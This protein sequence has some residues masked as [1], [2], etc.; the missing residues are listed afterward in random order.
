MPRS[1][2]SKLNPIARRRVDMDQI[3]AKLLAPQD[4]TK[5]PDSVSQAILEQYKLY[6]EMA[7]RLSSRRG[8]TNTFF[9]TLNTAIASLGTILSESLKERPKAALYL[10]LIV[11]LTQTGAWFAI[12]RSYQQLNSAKYRVI[13]A[14]EEH[15]PASPYWKAEW[16]ALGSGRDK[17][18]YWPIS[19]VEQIVPV[20]FAL[21][22]VGLM[23]IVW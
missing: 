9:L 5:R 15:L 19:Q 18:V 4:A 10:L 1:L 7:D 3:R 21:T 22:Y 11:L 2:P 12:L 16:A 17:R 13:G 23:A 14:L 8:L 6:V 20:L